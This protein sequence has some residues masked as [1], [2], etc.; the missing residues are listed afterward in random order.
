MKNSYFSLFWH[1]IFIDLLLLYWKMVKKCVFWWL[2]KKQWKIGYFL[3]IFS[4]F[5]TVFS[6]DS[7][8]YNSD[9]Y[10]KNS[11]FLVKNS[12]KCHFYM[13]FLCK[14]LVGFQGSWTPQDLRVALTGTIALRYLSEPSK[15]R[16]LKCPFLH[17]FCVFFYFLIRYSHIFLSPICQK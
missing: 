5:F 9:F 15:N 6:I 4:Y 12:E 17:I 11:D 7:N 10:V 14:C 3:G 2:C 13:F 16:V 1:S 8:S